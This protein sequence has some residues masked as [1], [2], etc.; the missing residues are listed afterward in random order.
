LD[1]LREYALHCK[2]IDYNKL[3][4]DGE[5]IGAFWVITYVMTTLTM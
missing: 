1:I 4:K 5:A 2:V 3:V